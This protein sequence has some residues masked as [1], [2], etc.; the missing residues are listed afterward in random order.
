MN[1]ITKIQAKKDHDGL[2][3]DQFLAP[4]LTSRTRA[5]QWIQ[6][7][8]VY[9]NNTLQLKPSF[10][11]EKGDQASFPTEEAPPAENTAL[12][13]YNFPIP[14]VYED[15]S[16]IVVDKPAGLVVHPACG[17]PDDTLVNALIHKLQNNTGPQHRPG[18]I[19]RLDKDVSGLL[20][21]SKTPQ[22]Q[23]F[24]ARQFLTKE[25][26]RKY[27]A[28]CYGPLKFQKGRIETFIARHPVDRK[29]F[30]S[31]SHCEKGKRAITLFQTLKE[32]SNGICLVEF[33]LL[34]GRTHQVRIHSLEM[35]EGIIGDTVYAHCKKIRDIKNHEIIDKIKQLDRIALHAICLTLIH[36]ETKKPMTFHSPFPEKLQSLLNST[37]I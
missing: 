19:H 27:Q 36:P 34:T 2:R 18:L 20:V 23:S 21:L 30:I 9:V 37:C 14:I 35:S 26:K 4:F 7:G 5:V 11:I 25:I 29:K 17:H 1:S 28:L 33:Q 8:K 3:L 13:P 15:D 24:L 16:L 22:A 31:S 10:R 6:Q 12:K 32:G